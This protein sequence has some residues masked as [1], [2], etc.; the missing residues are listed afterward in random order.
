MSAKLFTIAKSREADQPW[1][2][3]W[4][5]SATGYWVWDSADQMASAQ[6]LG[7]GTDMF[8]DENDENCHVPGTQRFYDAINS[9]FE[10]EQAAIALEHFG[11]E[12]MEEGVGT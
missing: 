1:R 7:D 10:N 2:F 9:Y 3:R 11:Y 12:Y 8:C 4:K 6:W 5:Q